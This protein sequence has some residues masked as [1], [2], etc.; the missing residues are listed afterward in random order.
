L[1]KFGLIGEQ[2]KV[3]QGSIID[4]TF[5]ETGELTIHS[6]KNS[7]ASFQLLLQSDEE[8]LLAVTNKPAFWKQGPINTL[9]TEVVCDGLEAEQLLVGLMEDDDRQLKADP[10]LHQETIHVPAWQKQAVWVELKLP[11]KLPAGKYT[12]KVRVFSH[13]MFEDETLV[14][15]LPFTIQL[16]D[17]TLPEPNARTFYL[18]LWQHCSNIARKHEVKLWSDEHFTILDGYVESLAAL[19]QKAISVIVSEIPWSGQ[20]TFQDR[21]SES[22]LFE[23]SM[24]AIRR[25]RGGNFH[26]DYSAMDRYIELCLKHGIAEEIE[27]FGLCNIWLGPEGGF[28]AFPQLLDDIRLRYLDEAT[29]TYRFIRELPQIEDYIRALEEHFAQEGLLSKVRVLADEPAD[30]EIYLRRLAWLRQTA[31]RFLYKAAINHIEMLEEQPER[32]VD[33]VPMF[34]FLCHYAEELPQLREKIKGKFLYYV[35]CGPKRPNT[36]LCSP[37]AE[38]RLIPILAAFMGLDG[39]LRWNYTVW[40]ER[41]RESIIYRPAVFPAG[42]TNFVYPSNSGKPILSLR[43]KALERG[44]EDFE[45]LK[46]VEERCSNWEQV[47]QEYYALILRELDLKL[48]HPEEYQKEPEEL[49]SL[50]E[51]DYEKARLRLL[52]ALEEGV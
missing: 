25:D 50:L 27:V 12:G 48:H 22:D 41:P 2:F 51:A 30:T 13:K 17:V 37:L 1:L 33:Y 40:P 7:R 44:I 19:G 43:Y 10:L 24:V 52:E 18:D 9:R 4:Y 6:P 39:F 31:P 16:H 45:L 8:F 28:H 29:G 11:Q 32:L 38:S 20:R 35:C 47:T 21:P 15:E 26:Y 36:F 49:Y 14:G 5:P 3:T 34:P 46:L 42:D 23:Y